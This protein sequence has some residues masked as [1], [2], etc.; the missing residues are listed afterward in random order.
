MAY[1]VGNEDVQ[2]LQREAITLLDLLKQNSDV[3]NGLKLNEMKLI[4]MISKTGGK[5]L[6]PNDLI[7]FRELNNRVL[8]K[9]P[10]LG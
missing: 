8:S 2:N 9:L 3:K 7:E 6:K 1:I 10:S 4:E 5:N